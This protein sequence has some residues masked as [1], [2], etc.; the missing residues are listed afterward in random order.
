LLIG[1]QF[2][3]LCTI[4]R[5]KIIIIII[6]IIIISRRFQ[7]AVSRLRRGLGFD[8]SRVHVASVVKKKSV[9]GIGFSPSTAEFPRQFIPPVLHTHPSPLLYTCNLSK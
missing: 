4:S 1:V 5:L 2:H 9:A 6:I 7:R 3:R 8:P